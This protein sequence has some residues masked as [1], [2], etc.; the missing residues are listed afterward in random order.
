MSGF[1]TMQRD[2]LDHPLLQ[3]AD[4]FR[5]W[6][7]MVATAAWKPTPFDISGKIVT[8]NRGQL[9]ASR[10]H[11]AKAWGMSPSAAERFLVRLEAEGM[12]KR[13]TGQ[14]KSVITICNYDK[15]QTR[16][17]KPGQAIEADDHPNATR[18]KTGQAT[19]Q[20]TGQPPDSHRTTKEQGNKGTIEPNG[21]VE[22]ARD[23]SEVVLDHWNCMARSC[24]RP[25]ARSMTAGRKAG[26]RSRLKDHTLDDVIQAIDH[27]PRSAFLRGV[28]GDWGGADLDFFLTRR[29]TITRTL[30]GKYDDRPQRP[31]HQSAPPRHGGV[32]ELERRI[33][34]RRAGEAAPSTGQHHA[35][36][37]SGGGQPALEAPAADR[38]G[39]S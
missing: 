5:A 29:E 10:S 13:E 34:S 2:A 3:E 15:Y 24:G 36:E 21:S 31:R 22:D 4:R 11:L 9:C 23:A 1:I 8:L 25:L 16:D 33:S 27:V 14:G 28:A 39:N 35:G 18:S 32:A 19:G 20:A 26:L 6:F 38:P 17:D 7:W 37:G 30:E 12:I